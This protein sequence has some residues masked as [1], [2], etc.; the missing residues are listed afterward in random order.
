MAIANEVDCLTDSN[1]DE[2]STC[3]SRGTVHSGS[4]LSP[5]KFTQIM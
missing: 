5:L 4:Q 3:E 2:A 1:E